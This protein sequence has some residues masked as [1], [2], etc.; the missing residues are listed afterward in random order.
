MKPKAETDRRI[1]DWQGFGKEFLT[2]SDRAAAVLGAAWLDVQLKRRIELLLVDDRKAMAPLFA[3]LGP[4]STFS[5]RIRVAY[6]LGIVSRA[7][8]ADLQLI[9]KIRN[10]FAHDLH[11]LSF[12]DDEIAKLCRQ[13]G[14]PKNRPS[15]AAVDW[16]PRKWYEVTVT[17]FA[18][19]ISRGRT[20]QQRMRRAAADG[21]SNKRMKLTALRNGRDGDGDMARPFRARHSASTS[22]AAYP[23][24]WADLGCRRSS[25]TLEPGQ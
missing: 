14:T 24:C 4:L 9:K 3:G 23:R 13:L 12:S 6:G 16:N 21:P 11:G 18:N 22:A 5:A 25:R 1:K 7:S 2:E 20:A 17:T 8:F 10:L 15:F 19:E